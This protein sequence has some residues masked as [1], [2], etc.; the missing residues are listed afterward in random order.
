[1]KAIIHWSGGETFIEGVESDN[2]WIRDSRVIE[3]IN[4]LTR[5]GFGDSITVGF[6]DESPESTPLIRNL[7][8][9]GPLVALLLRT[10]EKRPDPL[11]GD[12]Q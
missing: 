8:P 11:N 12:E 4:R 7:S 9:S 2:G 3:E 5:A 1:M 10:N 6:K